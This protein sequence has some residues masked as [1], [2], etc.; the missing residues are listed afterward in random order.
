MSEAE[1]SK[2]LRIATLAFKVLA[3]ILFLGSVIV[4]VTDNFTYKNLIYRYRLIYSYRY[5]L[6]ASAIGIAYVFCQLP[7]AIFH[8]ITGKHLINYGPMLY[9]ELFGD[10]VILSLLGTAIGA[11]FGATYDLKRSLD[12]V[13]QSD[14]KSKLEE[15]FNLG[16]VSA[17]LLLLGFLGFGASSFIS[18]LALSKKAQK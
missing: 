13:D 14:Y 4:L 10:K 9:F 2:T 16:F 1:V 12:G 3:L 5:M 15:F 17:S 7:I 8:L 6:Y 11:G 18:S